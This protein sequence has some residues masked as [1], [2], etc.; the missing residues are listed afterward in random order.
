MVTHYSSNIWFILV[1]LENQ[2]RF[3]LEVNSTEILH[4]NTHTHTHTH[5]HTQGLLSLS[6]MGLVVPPNHGNGKGKKAASNK[7]LCLRV[8]NE[9][10]LLYL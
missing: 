6:L 10:S 2:K 1:Q 8:L 9:L 5:T 3:S 7:Q 4:R